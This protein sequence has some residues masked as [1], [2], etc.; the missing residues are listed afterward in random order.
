[1]KKYYR[2]RVCPQ[3]K[4]MLHETP[5]KVLGDYYYR[6]YCE[7]HGNPGFKPV[8]RSYRVP[9]RLREAMRASWEANKGVYMALKDA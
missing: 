1:M 3:C 8:Y 4:E 9:N 5:Y 6:Y 2:F 7:L